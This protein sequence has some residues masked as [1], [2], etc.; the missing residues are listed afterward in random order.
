[1]HEEFTHGVNRL[2]RD[3]KIKSLL[4]YENEFYEDLKG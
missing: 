1:M 3:E 4:E 2:S